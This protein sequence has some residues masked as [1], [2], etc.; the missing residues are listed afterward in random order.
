MKETSSQSCLVLVDMINGFVR[1]GALADQSVGHIIEPIIKIVDDFKHKNYPIIA[2]CDAHHQASREFSAFAPHC[3]AHTTESELISELQPYS[4]V[5]VRIEKNSV[6][7]FV[8][9]A[10]KQ[11]FDQQPIYQNYIVVGLVSDICVLN[12]AS[13]LQAYLHEHD[14]PS[15]V[16]VSKDTS[17]TFHIEHHNKAIFNEMAYTLLKQLGVLV[18]DYVTFEQL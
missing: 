15:N 2:L 7:G 10:F 9:P 13:T 1:E 5:I 14:Y 4:D 8:A 17:D 16:I 11:W 18:H 12:F 6:N 3:L